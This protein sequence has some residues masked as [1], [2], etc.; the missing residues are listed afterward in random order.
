MNEYLWHKKEPIYYAILDQ[1]NCKNNI[2]TLLL[3]F[4]NWNRDNRKKI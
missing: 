2:K 1:T 3:S 4:F